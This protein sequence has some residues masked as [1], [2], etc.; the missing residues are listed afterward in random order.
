MARFIKNFRQFVNEAT[1]SVINVKPEDLE[2]SLMDKQGQDLVKA[3]QADS[4]SMTA[5]LESTSFGEAETLQLK[6]SG[7]FRVVSG[8]MAA[9]TIAVK[10]WSLIKNPT[11]IDA[12]NLK[13]D[14]ALNCSTITFNSSNLMVNIPRVITGPG[15]AVTQ[16][17]KQIVFQLV[18]NVEGGKLTVKINLEGTQI[19]GGL[20]GTESPIEQQ[21]PPTN[22]SR[23]YRGRFR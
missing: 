2:I 3:N 7:G 13:W 18:G 1:E 22:E 11:D 8:S 17:A 6:I 12:A 20:P 14:S 4:K 10:D 9:T 21:T 16:Y 15:K 5:W 19:L 23:L